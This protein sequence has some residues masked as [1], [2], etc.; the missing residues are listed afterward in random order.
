MKVLRLTR[1]P[2]DETQLSALRAAA[3]RLLGT[4]EDEI[5]VE[6]VSAT[7]STPDEVLELVRQ[8]GAAVLEAVLPVGLLAGVVPLL[9]KEGVPVIRAVMN[10]QLGPD[11]AAL[12]SFDHYELVE[13]VEVRTRPL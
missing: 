2:A 11:G 9:Q 10:R 8:H 4:A 7:V 6:T 12:F 13:A 1:H 5:Q 3:A